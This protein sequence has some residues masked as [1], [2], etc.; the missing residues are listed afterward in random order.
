MVTCPSLSKSPASLGGALIGGG[1][2]QDGGGGQTLGGGA[3]ARHCEYKCQKTD[4]QV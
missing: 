4:A 2:R 3:G 1:Q